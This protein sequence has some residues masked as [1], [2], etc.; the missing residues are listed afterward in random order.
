MTFNRN[1]YGAEDQDMIEVAEEEFVD[2]VLL[3]V[4]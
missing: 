1:R 4:L 2:K 3:I